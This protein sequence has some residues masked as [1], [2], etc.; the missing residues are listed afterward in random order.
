MI[1]AHQLV[2]LEPSLGERQQPVPAG[3]LERDWPAVA[4]SVEHDL[5]VR[6]RAREQLVP[7]PPRPRRPHTRHSAGMRVEWPWRQ[8]RGRRA[9][10]YPPALRWRQ[11]KKVKSRRKNARP[12]PAEVQRC[13]ADEPRRG[14]I[15]SHSRPTKLPYRHKPPSPPARLLAPIK[16]WPRPGVPSGTSACTISSATPRV[17]A[18]ACASRTK[19][20]PR[21]LEGPRNFV[22]AVAL[23]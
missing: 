6:D 11:S 8:L 17:W 9:G 5:L 15:K 10:K 1:A 14:V 16:T 19:A 23:A 22:L 2:A 4:P 18:E 12:R 13:G 7:G 20:A 3:V 21:W